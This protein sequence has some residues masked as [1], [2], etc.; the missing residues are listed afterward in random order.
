MT[1]PVRDDITR[2]RGVGP[3]RAIAMTMGVDTRAVDRAREGHVGHR[4][5]S[6]L[7]CDSTLYSTISV[8]RWGGVGIL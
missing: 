1:W 6:G 4:V 3:W 2:E 8:A 5:A 7:P